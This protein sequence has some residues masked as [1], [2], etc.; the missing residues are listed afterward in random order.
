MSVRDSGSS[1]LLFFLQVEA[2]CEEQCVAR[3]ATAGVPR[4]GR[5]TPD[6]APS[7]LASF[8]VVFA[9]YCDGSVFAGDNRII[10]DDGVVTRCHCRLAHLSA[11]RRR[12]N[13]VSASAHR[14]GRDQRR[15]L[16]QGLGDAGAAHGPEMRLFVLDDA[17]LG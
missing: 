16:R 7:P 10:G 2:C 1:D 6:P 13:A 8:N 3:S 14:V 17:G 11:A 12:Q 15:R 9:S 4:R 5:T